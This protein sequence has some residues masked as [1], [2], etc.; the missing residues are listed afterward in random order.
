MCLAMCISICHAN[1]KK[2]N[3]AMN[4]IEQVKRDLICCGQE[5]NC[6]KCC[7]KPETPVECMSNLCIDALSAIT[8]LEAELAAYRSLDKSPEELA[9][10]VKAMEEGRVVAL[11]C[12]VGDV[13]YNPDLMHPDPEW[14][15]TYEY[16]FNG[17]VSI[18]VDCYETQGTYN[19]PLSIIGKTVFLTREEAEAKLKELTNNER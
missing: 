7:H 18:G 5:R 11:P 17:N 13:L 16:V 10:M 12:K 19:I 3:R 1:G 14:D 2:G 9:K 8:A 4:N 15:N 6:L